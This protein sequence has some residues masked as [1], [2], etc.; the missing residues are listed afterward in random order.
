MSLPANVAVRL[1]D[2]DKVQSLGYDAPVNNH[3]LEYLRGWLNLSSEV[4]I[5]T[6]MGNIDWPLCPYPNYRQVATDIEF[7]ARSGVRGY[8]AQ[9]AAQPASDMTELKSYLIGR[10]TFDPTLNTTLLVE[11]FLEGFFGASAAPFVRAYLDVL[12]AAAS[13]YPG[14]GVGGGGVSPSSALFGNTTVLAA[15][16]ALRNASAAAAGSGAAKYH[17]R[18]LR[19]A[20]PIQYI[21][22]LRWE[23]YRAFCG[24]TACA[25]PGPAT[26]RAAFEEFSDVIQRAGVLLVAIPSCPSWKVS[27]CWNKAANVTG[28][29]AWLFPPGSG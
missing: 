26:K 21:L 27:D 29:G 10:T 8:F 15:A 3:S 22:L 25:W 13:V 24:E 12:E 5:W 14:F 23:E 6:Y 11:E 19:A 2:A 4:L 9:S 1:C 28:L 17:E 18:T 16:S 7:L 20:L